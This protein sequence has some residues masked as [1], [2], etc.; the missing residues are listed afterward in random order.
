MYD[1]HSIYQL[2]G[3][4]QFNEPM[5]YVITLVIFRP[6]FDCVVSFSKNRLLKYIA[7]AIY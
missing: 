2:C 6:I 5:L 7:R 3:P 4:L 1:R